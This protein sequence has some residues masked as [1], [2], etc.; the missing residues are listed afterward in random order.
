MFA[1][2]R[3]PVI[4]P[5]MGFQKQLQEFERLLVARKSCNGA[6]RVN[7][8]ALSFNTQN[9]NEMRLIQQQITKGARTSPSQPKIGFDDESHPSIDAYAS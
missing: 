2:K 1:S 8:K 6:Q 9:N 5:N 3:R 4:F 7:K